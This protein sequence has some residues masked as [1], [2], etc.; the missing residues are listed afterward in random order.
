MS[1]AKRKDIKGRNLRDN[2]FQKKDGRYEYRFTDKSGKIKSIYSWRLVASDKT[3]SG[4]RECKP[5]R[6][7]AASIQRD[8]EDHIIVD[9]TAT[10]DDYWCKMIQKKQGLKDYTKFPG[11][12]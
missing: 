9:R 7:M 3:P 2:E 12:I 6:E 8:I 4:K 10:V 11:K 5:L 1:S